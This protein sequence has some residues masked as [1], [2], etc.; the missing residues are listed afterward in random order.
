MLM[1]GAIFGRLTWDVDY[2]FQYISGM[3]GEALKIL[4]GC[5]ATEDEYRIDVR[6]DAGDDVSVHP[7]SDDGSVL[8]PASQVS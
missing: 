8:P 1:G 2:P 4:S 5:Y 6:I 7:I 3:I